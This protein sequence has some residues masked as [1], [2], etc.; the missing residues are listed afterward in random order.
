MKYR[1]VRERE[2]YED[3]ASGRVFVGVPGN[4][5]F[6][7]RLAS[8]ILQ[9]CASV[10]NTRGQGGRFSVYDPCCGAAYHLV[11]LGYLHTRRIGEIIGSDVDETALAMARRNL[12]MLSLEGLEQRMAELAAMRDAFGKRSHADALTSAARLRAQ[13]TAHS[14]ADRPMIRLFVADATDPQALA[15]GLRRQPVDIVIT[16]VPYGWHS[17]WHSAEGAD[18]PDGEPLRLMLEALLGVVS[19]N[20]VLAVAADKSQRIEH[21]RY[22]P[23]QRL[24]AGRRQ[25]AILRPLGGVD[26]LRHLGESSAV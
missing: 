12:S 26:R 8:E 18:Q 1:F 19:E 3:Y 9:R 4:P 10:L 14:P 2:N 21:E 5:A 13:L 11:V 7:V 20:S 22:V 24:R 6:P 17:G 16:D 25:I 23:L 15:R